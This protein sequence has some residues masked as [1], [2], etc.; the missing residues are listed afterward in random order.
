MLL[1]WAEA[2]SDLGEAGAHFWS[3]A[4]GEEGAVPESAS[5]GSSEAQED[6]TP[7]VYD[8]LDGEALRQR[9]EDITGG[10]FEA[11]AA[12]NHV[13]TSEKGAEQEEAG[14][15]VDSSSSWSSCEIFPLDESGCQGDNVGGVSPVMS[16]KK[17]SSDEEDDGDD[18]NDEDDEEDEEEDILHPNS[19]ASCSVLSNSPLSTGSSE[20]FLP[21]GPPD[22]QGPEPQ[23]QPSDAHSLLAEL[24]QQ[25]TQQKA[26]Y[27][28]RIQRL[29]R[30]N[31][32]LQGQIAVLRVNLE[33]QK[34]SQSVAEIKIRNMERAKA[35]ADLRNTTLQR[36]MELFFKMYGQIR[37]RGGGEGGGGG[38]GEGEGGRSRE[39]ILQSL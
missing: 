9:V 38:E 7:S 11:N 28:A 10:H 12:G 14:Q 27:Q 20:V 29:E 31:E 26:E 34:R 5:G 22:L 13:G 17:L 21:S 39:R 24:Q 15:T 2:W 16:P 4:G 35:D 1:S 30:C 36:E 32:V 8:N 3:S 18:N 19:P 25:M 37:G 33:Q 23:P 6:S